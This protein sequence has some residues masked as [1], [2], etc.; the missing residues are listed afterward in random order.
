MS[1]HGAGTFCNLSIFSCILSSVSWE[2]FLWMTLY[3]DVFL[4]FH[5][6]SLK[7]EH[8][9]GIRNSDKYRIPT[10]KVRKTN[11]SMQY[12]LKFRTIRKFARLLQKIYWGKGKGSCKN[13]N[14][15]SSILQFSFCS[16]CWFLS[17]RGYS[18][19]GRIL[20]WMYPKPER[21]NLKR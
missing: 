9:F 3:I 11:I 21:E 15:R 14:P 7:K 18:K 20:P 13:E 6:F 12:S 1:S 2:I 17:F 19:I 10:F 8:K 16:N 4:L 5:A